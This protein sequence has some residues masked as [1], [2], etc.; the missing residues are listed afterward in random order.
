[1]ELG[2]KIASEFVGRFS[3]GHRLFKGIVISLKDEIDRP[4]CECP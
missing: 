3:D 1:M 4:L 2:K